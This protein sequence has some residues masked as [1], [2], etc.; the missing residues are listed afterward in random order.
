MP[1][2]AAK[3]IEAPA[4]EVL[5][6]FP[7]SEEGFTGDLVE[8]TVLKVSGRNI[9]DRTYLVLEMDS[10]F[11]EQPIEL[12]YK[13]SDRRNS[14]LFKLITALKECGVELDSWK[15]LEGHKFL[16]ARQDYTILDRLT[17]EERS[18]FFWLPKKLVE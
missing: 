2:L 15:D 5:S 11:S 12:R 4:K 14:H 13:R 8:M 18:G 10:P 9:E 7:L 1:K 17:G 3:R 6:E 16:W